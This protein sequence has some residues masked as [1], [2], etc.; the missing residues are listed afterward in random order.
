MRTR[1]ALKS[2]G[3]IYSFRLVIPYV[4]YYFL[5]MALPFNDNFL[6]Q[7]VGSGHHFSAATRQRIIYHCLIKQEDAETMAPIIFLGLEPSIGHLK[8]LL[9]K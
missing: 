2:P 1:N 4:P 9:V 7:Q 3:L 6:E 8:K 5:K